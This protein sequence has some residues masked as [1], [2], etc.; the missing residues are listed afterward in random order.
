MDNLNLED[1]IAPNTCRIAKVFQPQ[2][3]DGPGFYPKMAWSPWRSI[4]DKR[5]E[6]FL[7]IVYCGKVMIYRV[8][9]QYEADGTITIS[10]DEDE[11]YTV[12]IALTELHPILGLVWYEK[13][14]L[15]LYLL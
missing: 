15:H 14:R 6:S 13:V 3:Q 2:K 1:S 7:T 11:P 12:G 9:M 4:N 8:S 5:G 10:A